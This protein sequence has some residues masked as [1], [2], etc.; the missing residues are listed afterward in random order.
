[1]IFSAL[2]API[3]TVFQWGISWALVTVGEVLLGAFVV[4]F[5]PMGLRFLLAAIGPII[6]F[7]IMGALWGFWY[8]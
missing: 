3:T 4:G 1:M 6:S 7:V 2:A 5:F 8:I